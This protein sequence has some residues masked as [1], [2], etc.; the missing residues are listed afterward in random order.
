[1]K[2]GGERER[3]SKKEE[4]E[5]KGRVLNLQLR[6]TNYS[7]HMYKIDVGMV[8]GKDVEGSGVQ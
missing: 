5:E 4:K 3:K 2:F 8:E 6:G 7:K 1:M